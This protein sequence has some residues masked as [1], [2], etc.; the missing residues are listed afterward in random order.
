MFELSIWASKSF[1][2]ANDQQG[3]K[4]CIAGFAGHGLPL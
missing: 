1:A 4:A 2:S 3:M